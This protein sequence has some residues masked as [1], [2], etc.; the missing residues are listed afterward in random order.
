[1]RTLAYPLKLFSRSLTWPLAALLLLAVMACGAATDTAPPA[2]ANTT[3]PA[4]APADTSPP[5]QSSSSQP[6]S[7]QP[8]SSAGDAAAMQP[9]AVAQ[10]ATAVQPTAVAQPTPAPAQESVTG[11]N[12]VIIVLDDEPPGLNTY[13]HSQGGRI[14][15]ENL[16]DPLG[17]FDKDNRQLVALSPYTGWEQVGPDRWRLNLREGVKFHNGEIWNGESAAWNFTN[18]SGN[19]QIGSN[20]SVGYT[21]T[22]RGEAVDEKTVDVICDVAC[23]IFVSTAVVMGAL[24]PEWYDN[25]PEDVT[26]RDNVGLGPYRLVEWLP[27]ISITTEAYPDYVPNPA[28]P[29]AQTPIIQEVTWLWRGEPTVRSAMVQAGEADLAYRLGLS[30]RDSVPV[31]QS[32]S[33]GTV[34]FIL[35]DNIWNPLLR[36]RNMRLAMVHGWDCQEMVEVLLE[37]TTTCRGSVAF[38]GVLGATEKNVAPREYNP[39]LV[40]EYLEKAGY[41]GEEIRLI[42]RPVNWPNQQ[43]LFEALTSYWRELGINITLT[44]P[45]IS[46][47]NA[48]RDCGIDLVTPEV[49][50]ERWLITAEPTTCD[51]ADMVETNK[52]LDSLDY[53]RFLSDVFSCESNR[54]RIC[55]PRMEELRVEALGAT[56]ERRKEL[57]ETL[58]DLVYDEAWIMGMFDIT[59]HFGK[60]E[61]LN[62]EPRGFDDRIRVS[63]MSWK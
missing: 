49:T 22:H 25:N 43:E 54:S 52:N 46:V 11:R 26:T 9:T 4:V 13:H 33:R 53:S 58:A 61:E 15:R 57:M 34:N 8:P 20:S 56:G 48:V 39:A 1:M 42:S 6:S 21:G 32:S 59:A 19:R 62:W 44:L 38:P 63:T 45:E 5:E 18:A 14:H 37:N 12:D 60:V 41:N 31:F 55:D 50:E 27:G 30:N 2:P 16:N 23:P 29:G 24:A 36:D 3:T 7:S 17:W 35:F 47:R 51:H 40:T 28:V 10:P